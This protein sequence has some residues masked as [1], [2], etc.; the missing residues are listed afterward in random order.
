[1]KSKA[2]EINNPIYTGEFHS[3]KSVSRTILTMSDASKIRDKSYPIYHDNGGGSNGSI[4]TTVYIGKDPIT[5]DNIYQLKEGD[6]VIG[7]FKSPRG[8][9]GPQGPQGE[10]GP[11][12]KQGIPGEIGPQ[13]PLGLPGSN[14]KSAFEEW[15]DKYGKGY[16]FTKS[17]A[18]SSL[19]NEINTIVKTM[20]HDYEQ[21][22]GITTV[23]TSDDNTVIVSMLSSKYLG[24]SNPTSASEKSGIESKA[25]H[26]HKEA[27]I[28]V[29]TGD[30]VTKK[31]SHRVEKVV[32]DSSFFNQPDTTEYIRRLNPIPGAKILP[33]GE[34]LVPVIYELRN[35]YGSPED[36]LKPCH[37]F[38]II[39][40]THVDG[41]STNTV[42][43]DDGSVLLDG[44]ITES[45][46]YEYF[47]DFVDIEDATDMAI[48]ADIKCIYSETTYGF[49]SNIKSETTN[50]EARTTPDDKIEFTHLK[51]TRMFRTVPP[52]FGSRTDFRTL[53]EPVSIDIFKNINDSITPDS[54]VEP[55]DSYHRYF[56]LYSGS[57]FMNADILLFK[58]AD[59]FTGG[60]GY[61]QKVIE[62][63]VIVSKSTGLVIRTFK[64]NE[65]S[66]EIGYSDSIIGFG[67]NIITGS[68][69]VTSNFGVMEIN[70]KTG[71]E[72]KC[73][74]INL[75]SIV[76]HPSISENP[77]YKLHCIVTPNPL[78]YER[79]IIECHVM[80][81]SGGGYSSGVKG[82]SIIIMDLVNST[83]EYVGEVEYTHLFTDP[84][85][86]STSMYKT[87][88]FVLYGSTGI[89]LYLSLLAEGYIASASDI[90][91]NLYM[92][93][94]VYK[95]YSDF[96]LAITGPKGEDGR[97]G[98][99]GSPGMTGPIGLTGPAGPQGARGEIGPA[100]PQGS[101]GPRGFQGEVGAN[102]AKGDTG[103]I[104]PPGPQ[105]VKGDPGS[106]AKS[107]F[108]TFTEHGYTGT[109]SELINGLIQLLSTPS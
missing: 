56:Q 22:M 101:Q 1:M 89:P 68:I 9:I 16:K 41:V 37:L 75:S 104:G 73:T 95:E 100:G 35:P 60:Y 107:V 32:F 55:F 92:I 109:E 62:N 53:T 57:E 47:P 36:T 43:Y 33:T 102:G 38:G 103:P 42:F 80:Y 21:I 72:I 29:S 70:P 93:S 71:A 99:P 14:G 5:G 30:P 83:Y 63:M 26:P 91:H 50:M 3:D 6:K 77:A 44:E 58:C 45:R 94:E 64:I 74:P 90:Q 87:L 12:G 85:D 61:H 20:V 52:V 82:D 79:L 31:Y 17:I 105:G 7:E 40:L 48:F 15:K 25:N 88:G 4:F 51:Q 46:F 39:K 98:P 97:V 106:D 78:S 54:V 8:P 81:G 34:I 65:R 28:I 96:L 24:N 27:V 18:D 23:C 76:K 49:Y 2:V 84:S 10:A 13:G 19:D 67:Q 66:S 59:V 86:T 11:A 108:V 69:Y